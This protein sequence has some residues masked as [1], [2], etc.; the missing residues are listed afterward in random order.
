[1]K[2]SATTSPNAMMGGRGVQALRA[3]VRKNTA[4]AEAN[5]R[6]V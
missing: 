6:E 4:S 2:S 3:R 5:A 1:M